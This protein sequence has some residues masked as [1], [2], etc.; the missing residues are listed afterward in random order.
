MLI[1]QHI[2]KLFYRKFCKNVAHTCTLFTTNSN[3]IK[4]VK[5]YLNKD[6][7]EDGRKGIGRINKENYFIR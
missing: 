2:L 5:T 3:L 1:R 6:N 7:Y 4:K